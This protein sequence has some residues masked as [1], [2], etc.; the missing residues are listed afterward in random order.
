VIHFEPTSISSRSLPLLRHGDQWAIFLN[1]LDT[2]KVKSL[3]KRTSTW[4]KQK[5]SWKENATSMDC[6]HLKTAH[7]GTK[8]RKMSWL[9]L[10]LRLHHLILLFRIQAIKPVLTSHGPIHSIFSKAFLGLGVLLVH[11]AES[12]SI[13]FHRSFHPNDLTNFVCIH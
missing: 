8:Y 1:P 11:T 6:G 2:L 5:S 10:L 7:D 4:I 9:F 3:R 12:V 13:F